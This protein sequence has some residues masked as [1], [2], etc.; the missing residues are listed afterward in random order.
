MFAMSSHSWHF[1]LYAWPSIMACAIGRCDEV[2]KSTAP[3]GK[4]VRR[5]CHHTCGALSLVHVP[6]LVIATCRSPCYLARHRWLLM[7]WPEP[8]YDI[9]VCMIKSLKPGP[10][11]RNWHCFVSDRISR[12]RIRSRRKR[13]NQRRRRSRPACKPKHSQNGPTRIW[14]PKA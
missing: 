12:T 10:R 2:Y 8:K 4:K 6:G 1:I 7:F 5:E 13:T 14:S 11:F 9:N 3:A